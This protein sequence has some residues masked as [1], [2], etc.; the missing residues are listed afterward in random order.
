MHRWDTAPASPHLS[1]TGRHPLFSLLLYHPLSS[2]RPMVPSGL[3][4]SL[5]SASCHANQ[6]SGT[7]FTRPISL[8]WAMGTLSWENSGTEESLGVYAVSFCWAENCAAGR[9]TQD[10]QHSR[11]ADPAETH[12]LLDAARHHTHQLEV[13]VEFTRL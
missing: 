7:Q 8:C 5:S 9:E 11:R 10:Y 6:R 3:M 2:R 13:I 1:A 12:T 4:Y